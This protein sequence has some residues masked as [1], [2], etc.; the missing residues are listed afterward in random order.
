MLHNLKQS[1][2][3]NISS[4]WIVSNWT[5]DCLKIKRY[6]VQII[7]QARSQVG[8]GGL[9]DPPP[10]LKLSNPR[11]S[12]ENRVI[13]KS[14]RNWPIWPPA[15]NKKVWLLACLHLHLP[16]YEPS[17]SAGLREVCVRCGCKGAKETDKIAKESKENRSAKRGVWWF[18]ISG[19]RWY[20]PWRHLSLD[21]QLLLQEANSIA[22]L[23]EGG[24][25]TA[26]SIWYQ[27]YV[28]KTGWWLWRV[29]RVFIWRFRSLVRSTAIPKLYLWP[30]KLK[31]LMFS[32]VCVCLFVSTLDN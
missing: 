32:P 17:P 5:C 26:Y 6:G 20:L 25:C 9:F 7:F 30:S 27:W 2:D 4:Q 12:Q 29:S 15:P 14:H 24:N 8:V 18:S 19:S 16:K 28:C 23:V 22:S 21:R 1:V 31:K 11:R 13:I 3:P 10:P